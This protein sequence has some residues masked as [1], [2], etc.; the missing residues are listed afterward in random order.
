[1][2]AFNLC[3]S[4]ENGKFSTKAELKGGKKTHSMRKGL[5]CGMCFPKHSGFSQALS[6]CFPALFLTPVLH[7]PSALPRWRNERLQQL[8]SVVVPAD[9]LKRVFL[10]AVRPPPSGKEAPHLSQPRLRVFFQNITAE[11]RRFRKDTEN[12]QWKPLV[13]HWWTLVSQP[14]VDL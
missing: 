6:V 13:C 9:C 2:F 8:R 12:F 4:V 7:N 11:T 5:F 3:W 1:M 10:Q 14:L